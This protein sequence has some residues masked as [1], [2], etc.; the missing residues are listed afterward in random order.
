MKLDQSWFFYRVLEIQAPETQQNPSLSFN[1][2][3][4]PHPTSYT[5]IMVRLGN[6]EYWRLWNH[7][8]FEAAK[9]HHPKICFAL[10]SACSARLHWREYLAERTVFTLGSPLEGSSANHPQVH[11]KSDWPL[12]FLWLAPPPS[13]LI[14]PFT[15]P[16]LSFTAAFP[17]P[18]PPP[19]WSIQGHLLTQGDPVYSFGV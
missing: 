18:P 7:Q 15:C 12:L 2:L 4:N 16:A 5:S 19:V 13:W 11:R 6:C 1:I 8:V 9:W 10:V 17:P 14:L 3:R